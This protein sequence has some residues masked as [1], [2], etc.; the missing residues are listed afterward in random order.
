[1]GAAWTTLFTY[2]TMTFLSHYLGQKH[3]PIKYNLRK[4]GLFLTSAIFLVLV[5]NW[6]TFESFLLTFIIHSILIIIYLGIVHIV[7]N[8]LKNYNR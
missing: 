1:M 6:L 7:E 8:P 2:A 3:Y 5:G 4:V